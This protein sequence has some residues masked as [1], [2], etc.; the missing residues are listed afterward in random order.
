MI[1]IF[2]AVAVLGMGQIFSWL[3]RDFE[4]SATSQAH[5]KVSPAWVGSGLK[6]REGDFYRLRVTGTCT[7]GSGNKFGP[8]GTAPAGGKIGC[9]VSKPKGASTR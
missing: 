3:I 5:V 6:V 4:W 2:S 1:L 9:I 8:E 7:D